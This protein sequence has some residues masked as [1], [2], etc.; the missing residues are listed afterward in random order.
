GRLTWFAEPTI[1]AGELRGV[2]HLAL[3]SPL[4]VQ[5]GLPL[6][7]RGF[8]AATPR[9]SVL[10]GGVVL[11]AEASP[12]PRRR[13]RIRGADE[14][15]LWQSRSLALEA[16]TERRIADACEGWLVCATPRPISL[17]SLA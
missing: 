5:S 15:T 9:G 7:L 8:R 17:T 1:T 13:E 4:P 6:V 3:E 16:L 10:A 12:L 14:G 2:A 11:D